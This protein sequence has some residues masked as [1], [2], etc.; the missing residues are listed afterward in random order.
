MAGAAL[1]GG[2][3][4]YRWAMAGK[5]ERPGRYQRS[6][7]G[8]RVTRVAGDMDAGGLGM[9]LRDGCALMALR[10][11]ARRLMV[12]V[13][14]TLAGHRGVHRCHGHSR[15]VAGRAG[16]SVVNFMPEGDRPFARGLARGGDADRD[17]NDLG[18]APLLVALGAVGP[19]RVLVVADLAA[20]RRLESELRAGRAEV[21]GQAGELLVSGVWEGVARQ[22]TESVKPPAG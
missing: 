15:S 22:G 14:A 1:F 4:V 11:M 12:L 17:R 20:A 3:V 9:G 5:A 21:A 16:K 2:V 13:M 18:K 7:G 6:D 10:A 8:G 19:A